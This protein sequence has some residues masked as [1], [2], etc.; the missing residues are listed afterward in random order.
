MSKKKLRKITKAN[1]THVSFVPKGANGADFLIVKADGEAPNWQFEAPILKLDEDKR[2]VTGI[3]YAPS[4]VDSQGEFMEADAIEKAAHDFMINH[5]HTDLKHNF[6]ENDGVSV[7][8][9]FVAKSDFLLDDAPIVKGTWLLTT[10][11]SD[12]KLWSGIKKGEYKGYSMGGTG[13][14]EE[15]EVDDDAISKNESGLFALLKDFF[16]GAK[17][18]KATTSQESALVVDFKAKALA[19]KINDGLSDARWALA[20]AMRDILESEAEDKKALIGQQIDSYKAYVLSELDSMGVK[21]MAEA[22][23]E[24]LEKAGKALSTANQTKIKAAYES[25]GELL[26]MTGDN[27]NEE[28]LDMKKED[29]EA[30]IKEA[31]SPLNAKIEAL[32]KVQGDQLIAQTEPVEIT[33]EDLGISIQEALAPLTERIAKIEAARG[34]SNQMTQDYQSIEKGNEPIFHGLL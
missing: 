14:R 28:E 22:L 8:E 17:V 3:V 2:L 21:K 25:L 32:E 6:V 10:K 34:T 16:G 15:V 11:V 7:V 26:S 4:V 24:P 1:I 19:N 20:D 31:I 5:R 13:V 27:Q 9:S 29:L 18:E 30:V 23:S 12:D 33:K